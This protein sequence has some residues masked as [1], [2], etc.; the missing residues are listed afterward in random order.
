ML[1]ELR[2]RIEEAARTSGRS[3]NAE[4]V[5]RLTESLEMPASREIGLLEMVQQVRQGYAEINSDEGLTIE[6]KV[7][8]TADRTGIRDV[9]TRE[10]YEK[11]MRRLDGPKSRKK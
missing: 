4:I 2:A 7:V 6:I 3:M 10:E 9:P 5:A 8:P 1:P 11:G